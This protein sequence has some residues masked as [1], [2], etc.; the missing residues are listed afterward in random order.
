MIGKIDGIIV[1]NNVITV[2]YNSVMLLNHL[3]FE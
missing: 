2:I 1:L 3:P